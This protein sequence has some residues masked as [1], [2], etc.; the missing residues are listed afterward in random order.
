MGSCTC[1]EASFP[2]VASLR[3]MSWLDGEVK[4]ILN[5]GQP[6]ARKYI[7]FLIRGGTAWSWESS[8]LEP[9]QPRCKCW[10]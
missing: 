1:D 3:M 8:V 5:Y 6:R 10:L 7:V 2:I 4:C 9:C